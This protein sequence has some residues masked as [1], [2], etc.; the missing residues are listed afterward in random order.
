MRR[1]DDLRSEVWDGAGEKE[2]G[3]GG[4]VLRGDV[5]GEGGTEGWG[6]G[7][8][9]CIAG[10]LICACSMSCFQCLKGKS[11]ESI[12]GVVMLPVGWISRHVGM[13]LQS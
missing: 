10:C 7:C 9:G 12:L 2:D 4:V 13:Y 11:K 3:G 6:C 1:G 5:S 8:T